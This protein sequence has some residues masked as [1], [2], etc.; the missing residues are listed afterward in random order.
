QIRNLDAF[1][2]QQVELNPPE[3][4]PLVDNLA[5]DATCRIQMNMGPPPA[6]AKVEECVKRERRNRSVASAGDTTF[7]RLLQIRHLKHLALVEAVCNKQGETDDA[8]KK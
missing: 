1:L 6:A 3:E 4:E 2:A 5:R 8:L 7:H